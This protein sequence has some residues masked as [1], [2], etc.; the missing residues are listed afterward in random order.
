MTPQPNED[1]QKLIKRLAIN[2]VGTGVLYMGATWF[3][4]MFAHLRYANYF[5]WL[6]LA[7]LA[8][9]TAYVPAGVSINRLEP[10]VMIATI[11]LA[12]FHFACC[13][14]FGSIALFESIFSSMRRGAGGVFFIG[15]LAFVMAYWMGQIAWDLWKLYVTSKALK[16][17]STHGFEPIL[18]SPDSQ[19]SKS[20][21]TLTG[22]QLTIDQ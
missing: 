19:A 1:S 12:A 14:I 21:P 22:S 7:C 13:A 2:L 10:G 5:V 15:I 18:G 17:P 8:A 6:T 3:I 9:G 20:A 16:E 4:I 11:T